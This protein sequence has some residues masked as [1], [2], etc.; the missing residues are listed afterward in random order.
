MISTKPSQPEYWTTLASIR[1]RA[2]SREGNPSCLGVLSSYNAAAQRQPWFV[3]T[4]LDAGLTGRCVGDFLA[5]HLPEPSAHMYC[6]LAVQQV[7]AWLLG[8]AES[9]AGFLSVANSAIPRTPDDCPNAKEA[10]VNVSRRSRRR[11]TR[12]GMVPRSASGRSVGPEYAGM[13]IEYALYHWRVGQAAHRSPSL[14]R[15]LS[16]LVEMTDP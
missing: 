6:R 9:L 13:L 5:E 14:K 7:E 16:R 1:D 3:L 2:T 4:D 10:M 15:C 8:D 11:T 12:E